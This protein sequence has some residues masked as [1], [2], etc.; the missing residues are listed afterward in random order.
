LETIA[1]LY[2]TRADAIFTSLDVDPATVT[3]LP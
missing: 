3:P 2:Q 1:A